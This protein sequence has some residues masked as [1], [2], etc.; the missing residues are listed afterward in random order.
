MVAERGVDAHAVGS[1]RAAWRIIARAEQKDAQQA[2]YAR[3]YAG[4]V[5]AEL[6]EICDSILELK[7]KNS[8]SSTSAGESNE[9]YFKTK[10]D[11]YQDLAKSVTGDAKSKVAEEVIVPVTRPFTEYLDVPCASPIVQTAQK[12][13]EVPLVQHIDEIVDVP[14]VAQRH[15]ATIQTVQKTVDVPQVRFLDRVDGVPVVMQRQTPQERIQERLA[16]KTDV[17]VP[18]VIEES[19]EVERLKFQL[20]EGESTL[21]ADNK[22][23]FKLDGSCAA[24]AP[25]W[26]ELRG[27]RDEE[28]V[29][30][31]DINKLPN[32]TDSLEFF[33]EIL[34]S[35][36][37]IQ[38][39]S[40]KR[41]VTRR[42]R[43]VFRN[44]SEL[45]DV[46]SISMKIGNEIVDFRV[47]LFQQEQADDDNKKT[48]C[49]VGI[50]R[51]GDEDTSL[52]IHTQQQHNNHHRK[53]WQQAGQTEEERKEE[54]GQGEREKGRKDE[55]GRG[56]EGKT[57][58]KK[59][60]L[61]SRMT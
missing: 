50:G 41:G 60:K 3:E 35:P 54:K 31:R 7:D 16:E 43:A 25:E 57:K 47:S 53:Q 32:D 51:A 6:P 27:L 15:F 38:L 59:G 4:E 5:E 37:P 33:K 55:R 30:I 2:T 8:V 22:L 23:S 28:L 49:L 48:F 24:Q 58:E 12:T 42:A 44:S 13:V 36:G 61:R 18:R 56:Q 34:P 39:Q 9:L 52:A 20:P 45:P 40:D 21:L 14:I 17:P 26:K 19:L 10:G 1:R 46:N 29:T 11:Y